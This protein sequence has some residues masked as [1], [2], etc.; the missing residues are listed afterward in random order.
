MMLRKSLTFLLALFITTSVLVAAS[1]NVG[2]FNSSWLIQNNLLVADAGLNQTVNEGD[3]VL[4]DG[5]NSYVYSSVLEEWIKASENPMLDIGLPG[6]WDDFYAY[7]PAVIYDGVTYHMWYS[8]HNG[9]NARIG[10][11]TS[12]DG[13][14]WTKSAS[15]PVLDI[16]PPGSWEDYSVITPTVIYDGITYHMWYSGGDAIHARVGYAT[17]PDGITWTKSASNPV[18]DLGSSG[19][20]DD[21]RAYIPTVLYDGTTYHMWY[22][23]DDGSIKYRIGYATSPDGVAWTKYAANPVLDLG[24][25]GSWDDEWVY[26][27]T[28][29]YDGAT[30]HMWYAGYDGTNGRIGYATSS[31]GTSWTKSASNPVLDIGPSNSWDD[32]HVEDPMVLYDGV[33]YHMWYSGADGT[34]ARIGYAIYSSPSNIS[35]IVSYEWDFTSD[36]IY[37]YVETASS[38]PDGAFDGKTTHIYGD[39]GVYTATLRITDENGATDTDTTTVT[40]NNLDPEITS[41]D[42]TILVNTPRTQG[43]WSHQCTVTEP[44]GDHTGLL[45]EWIDPIAAQSQVFTGVS[46]KGEVCAILDEKSAAMSDMLAKAKLQLMAIWLNVVSGKLYIDSPLDLPSLTTATTVREAIDEI[47]SVILSGDDV[48]ELER[49]KDIADSIN[50]FLGIPEKIAEIT[51]IASDPG[52]DDSMFNWSFGVQNIYYNNGMGPDPYPSPDGIFPFEAKDVV[53]YVYTGSMI[54]SLTVWDDDGG[55]AVATITLA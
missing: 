55:T 46:S 13:I 9:L 53:E 39:N 21:F 37:D 3:V 30:Y 40:V 48:S 25:P 5:S 4:L 26:D 54:V 45:Q 24:S 28:A 10:Y 38:A 33:T 49:V 41:I 22:A 11:A 32:V 36:G 20:W 50:N 19:S 34:N 31:D 35:N 47:E 42:T 52:S 27:P 14:T 18:L 17:S 15:N 7:E 16:G 43:Y 1:Q 44:Y 29:F 8:G 12:P 51:V 6:S 2:L 23:G